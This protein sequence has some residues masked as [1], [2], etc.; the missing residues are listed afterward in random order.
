[1]G[2][3]DSRTLIVSR[4]VDRDVLIDEVAQARVSSKVE[5]IEPARR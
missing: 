5:Q 4:D 3:G 2:G 1:V